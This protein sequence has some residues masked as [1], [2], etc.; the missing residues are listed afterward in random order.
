MFRFSE[1]S[2][3]MQDYEVSQSQFLF[4]RIQIV[5]K[6][7]CRTSFSMN[8]INGYVGPNTIVIVKC[9][10]FKF[11]IGSC[12]INKGREKVTETTAWFLSGFAWNSFTCFLVI[13]KDRLLKLLFQTF[14]ESKSDLCFKGFVS[15]LKQDILCFKHQC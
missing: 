13:G 5:T 1:Y 7:W 4:L 10:T 9:V 15:K 3:F 11:Y 2:A 6:Y 8:I 14:Y 12:W